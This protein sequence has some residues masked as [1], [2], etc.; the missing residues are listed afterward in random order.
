LSHFTGRRDTELLLSTHPYALAL[1]DIDRAAS[2]YAGAAPRDA[3]TALDH[4]FAIAAR[5]GHRRLFIDS[6]V[7]LRPLLRAYIANARPFRMLAS[8][9]LE[10]IG[11]TDAPDERCIVE[12]LTEREL[13]VLRYLPTMLSNREIA[14]EMYF[15]VNTVKT[16]LKSIYRKLQV[17]RRRDAVERARALSII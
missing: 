7:P 1:D 4:A 12:T 14:A 6:G 10:R 13:G 8:Q 16:H 2:F 15:S 5:N 9:M 3:W 17:T 11:A